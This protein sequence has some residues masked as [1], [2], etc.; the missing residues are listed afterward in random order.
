V[1]THGFVGEFRL[2]AA[3]NQQ[4]PGAIPFAVTHEGWWKSLREQR[5]GGGQLAVA[6]TVREGRLD[7]LARDAAAL[8]VAGDALP[9]PALERELVLGEAPRVAGVVDVAGGL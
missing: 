1:G 2:V 6:S 5:C 9:A 8:E 7:Q 3:P 4:A